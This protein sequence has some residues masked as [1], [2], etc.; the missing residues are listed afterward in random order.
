[1]PDNEKPR[2]ITEV[3]RR[4]E[5]QRRLEALADGRRQR[6]QTFRPKKG[7]GSYRRRGRHR[8]LADP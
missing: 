1:M 5:R 7:K 3:A 4:Q 8:K 2:L 6:A